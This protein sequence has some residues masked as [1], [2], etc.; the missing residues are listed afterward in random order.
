LIGT[1]KHISQV[2]ATGHENINSLNACYWFISHVTNDIGAQEQEM[3][4]AGVCSKSYVVVSHVRLSLF[5]WFR[6]LTA[7]CFLNC[8]RKPCI[9]T[10]AAGTVCNNHA[11]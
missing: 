7:D 11:T 1:D 8:L 4:R 2:A 6:L 10:T 9:W 5:P 3:R